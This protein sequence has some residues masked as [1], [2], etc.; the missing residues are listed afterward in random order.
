[1]LKV[2]KGFLGGECYIVCRMDEI[3][4]ELIYRFIDKAR[5]LVTSVMG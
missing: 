2:E 4:K 3:D 1:M 5:T